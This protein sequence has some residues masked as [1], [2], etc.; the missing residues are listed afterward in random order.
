MSFVAAARQSLT[1]TARASLRSASS[2]FRAGARRLNS[3][4]AS[5]PKSD[6]PWIIGSALLFGPAFLY[7]ISPSARKN[8]GHVHND[9]HDFPGHK[10]HALEP[11]AK[12]AEPE[13]EPEPTVTTEPEPVLMK[14][15]EGTEVNI[16][17]SLVASADDV[18][19]ADAVSQGTT[20]EAASEAPAVPKEP[21]VSKDASGTFQENGSEGPTDLGEARKA[22][23]VGVEP[24]KAESE[25]S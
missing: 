16:A 1:S 18:P 19:K 6:K 11:V 24:K 2:T 3:H 14:D 12:P 21:E 17:D 20:S 5:T 4:T 7:L 13:P 10:K 8:T 25:S 9:A 15:D 23:K 22:A